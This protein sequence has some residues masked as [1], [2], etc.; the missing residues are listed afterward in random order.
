M[1]VKARTF[2]DRMLNWLVFPGGKS[3]KS[4]GLFHELD[5]RRGPHELVDEAVEKVKPKGYRD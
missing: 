5:H 1:V 2:F 3:V 4:G